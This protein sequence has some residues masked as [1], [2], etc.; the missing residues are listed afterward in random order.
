MVQYT[1]FSAGLS[2]SGKGS[3]T[4]LRLRGGRRVPDARPRPAHHRRLIVHPPGHTRIAQKSE[5]PVSPARYSAPD[6]IRTFQLLVLSAERG[7]TVRPDD[8]A[9]EMEIHDDRE[10]QLSFVRSFVR[11]GA[12]LVD[13]F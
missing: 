13:C 10:I 7:E 1:T 3:R 4:V 12:A 6:C 8:D 11:S 5:N 2:V 9:P